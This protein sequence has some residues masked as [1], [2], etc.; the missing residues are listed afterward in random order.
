MPRRSEQA[1][2]CAPP[3]RRAGGATARV[4]RAV[5]GAHAFPEFDPGV[6]VALQRAQGPVVPRPHEA[7]GLGGQ[8][9]AVGVRGEERGARAPPRPLGGVLQGLARGGG[10]LRELLQ[11]RPCFGPDTRLE[12]A[13]GQPRVGVAQ[14]LQRGLLVPRQHREQRDPRGEFRRVDGQGEHGELA[15]REEGLPRRD[16]REVRRV[17]RHGQRGAAD[18]G[19]P[20]GPRGLPVH[21]GGGAERCHEGRV[22]QE[23]GQRPISQRAKL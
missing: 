15:R 12:C 16:R 13:V 9:G 17:H 8:H 10:C 1:P 23:V 2:P 22:R 14:R 3:R 11:F 6:P 4:A 7:H 21:R 19:L 5:V 18:A 20:R